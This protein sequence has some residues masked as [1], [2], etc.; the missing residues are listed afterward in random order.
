MANSTSTWRFT[1]VL[2]GGNGVQRTLPGEVVTGPNATPDTI[3][4]DL[5][6]ELQR[7]QPG[8]KFSVVSFSATQTA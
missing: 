1:L 8:V 2:Q 7:T 4:H 3:L 5:L 6:G